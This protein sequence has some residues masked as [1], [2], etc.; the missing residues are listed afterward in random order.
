MSRRSRK[1]RVFAGQMGLGLQFISAATAKAMIDAAAI[2]VEEKDVTYA[3]LEAAIDS[4]KLP[5]TDPNIGFDLKIH[6]T[7]RKLDIN[8]LGER[9]KKVI[10]EVAQ[11]SAKVQ[12]FISE[13]AKQTNDSS[14]PARLR[15]F[16]VS[17]YNKFY[18]EDGIYGDDLFEAVRQA[19]SESVKSDSCKFATL[20]ILVHLFIIC[21]VFLRPEDV[22]NA[23]SR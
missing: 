9:T 12:K 14:F 1:N 19:A 23:A 4:L 18:L 16:F 17:L 15:Y 13:R 6:D 5:K 8:N 22:E 7:D 20:A 21:D 11:H 10:V 3:S 2:E